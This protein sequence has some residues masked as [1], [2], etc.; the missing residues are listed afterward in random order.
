MSPANLFPGPLLS[1]AFSSYKYLPFQVWHGFVSF[2]TAF[3]NTDFLR[4]QCLMVR[5]ARPIWEP[6]MW[7]IAWNVSC[8]WLGVKACSVV[9]LRSG[10]PAVVQVAMWMSFLAHM[11]ATWCRQHLFKNSDL[12]RT[13]ASDGETCTRSGLVWVFSCQAKESCLCI[14]SKILTPTKLRLELKGRTS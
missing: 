11:A 12:P 10:H 14:G 7:T 4:L 8:Y 2:W 1:N 9:V 6:A 13:Y 5:S 3:T